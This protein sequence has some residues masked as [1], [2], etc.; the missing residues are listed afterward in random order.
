MAA[1]VE[2]DTLETRIIP[3]MAAMA[4]LAELEVHQLAFQ[5]LRMVQQ[6]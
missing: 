4:T 6:Q 5:P 2:M 3:A 1:V